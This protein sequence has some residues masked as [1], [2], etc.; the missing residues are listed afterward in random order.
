MWT[1]TLYIFLA[2]ASA[3][4]AVYSGFS[5]QIILTSGATFLM[6]TFA[7]WSIVELGKLL[8]KDIVEELQK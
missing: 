5:H 6:I 7:L 2:A 4:T 1:L 3:G 8:T